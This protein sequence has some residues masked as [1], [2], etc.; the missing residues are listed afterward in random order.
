MDQQIV[1]RVAQRGRAERERYQEAAE[2]TVCKIIDCTLP[3]T[4]LCLLVADFSPESGLRESARRVL[5]VER[6]QQTVDQILG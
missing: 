3:H 5:Q 1:W 6:L 4:A 2:P